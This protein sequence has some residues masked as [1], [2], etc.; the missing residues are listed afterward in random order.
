MRV[1]EDVTEERAADDATD[2]DTD[3]TEDDLLGLLAV[4][5]DEQMLGR[6]E[7]LT[8]IGRG[9]MAV[10]WAARLSGMRGFSKTF[11]VKT[12]LPALS[13]SPRLQRMFLAEAKIASRIKH[14]NV[15][16]ILD[17]GED[18]GTLYLVLEWVD[19][20]PLSTL[21]RECRRRGD[22]PVPSGIAARIGAKAARGLH[23]AHALRRDDGELYGVV[24]R[25]VSPQNI[26][27][28]CEGEVKIVDFGVAKV[29]ERSDRVTSSGFIKGKVAY[30]APE[31]VHKHDVDARADIFALGTV[32][33][34]LAS[35]AH[36]FRRRT[37]LATLLE[38]GAQEPV[39][40][41]LPGSPEQLE[42]ILARA[43]ARSPDDR[44]PS[45]RELAHDLGDS[46]LARG[47]CVGVGRLRGRIAVARVG[48]GA[49][50]EHRTGGR[51]AEDA[52]QGLEEAGH[53]V[54]LVF[55]V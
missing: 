6:Y 23:A 9:G 35:G 4:L 13:T 15:C 41:S 22:G 30:L 8:P 28:T 33:L 5:G 53:G 51:A 10:V 39:R 43:L 47:R 54:R 29:A 46:H 14:P 55:S 2:V 37:E 26:L 36:P 52:E 44:Y 20:D 11:A 40:P 48:R 34:E 3:D 25:D 27:L 7:L 42:S 49:R 32:L 1:E 45:M 18:R 19:G 38:I 12:M 21:A 16:E 17:V 24:H 50:R 31:Q